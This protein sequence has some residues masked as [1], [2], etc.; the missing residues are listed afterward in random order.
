MGSNHTAVCLKEYWG[1]EGGKKEP[2]NVP[3]DCIS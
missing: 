2:G 3:Q 1:G